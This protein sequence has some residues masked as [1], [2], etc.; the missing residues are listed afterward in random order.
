MRTINDIGNNR[1]SEGR[2][3]NAPVVPG[4]RICFPL[5]LCVSVVDLYGIDFRTSARVP[6][7]SSMCFFS[8]ISGGVMAMTSPA[9][10]TITP[11]S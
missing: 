9:A 8:A 5:R 4:D 10:R 2:N 7:I 11:F 1:M 3:L 6:T